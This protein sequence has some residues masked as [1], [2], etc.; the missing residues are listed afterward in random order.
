MAKL[1]SSTNLCEVLK[2]ILANL[3]AMLR[4]ASSNPEYVDIIGINATGDVTR[5]IDLLAEEFVV[6][7][8]KK[9]DLK[10]W[11]V[12]EEEGVRR[13][14]EKPELVILLDPLD[15][16]LN[17]AL[18]IPFASIS[19]AAYRVGDSI[20]RPLYG[21]VY[22][23]FSET[24]IEICDDKVFFNDKPIEGYNLRGLE[25]ISIYTDNP[26]HIR[27]VVKLIESKG[28]K[29][30][31]RTMGS[32]AL[33]S[34]LAALGWIGHFIHVTGRLRNVDVAVGLALA[35]KLGASVYTEPSL[36]ELSINGIEF[37]RKVVI[38]PKGSEVVNI[39]KYF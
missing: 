22:S 18:N 31:V 34:A 33:E 37:V 2:N 30:K 16:S 11:I 24:R 29:V 28:I 38:A 9:L 8:V 4:E 15:G 25:V 35:A 6:H 1:K 12:S 7:E 17:Y 21:G 32:A 27:A 36:E 10:A 20:L 13:L 5:K 26:E 19:L 3:V 14:S 23:V 39:V